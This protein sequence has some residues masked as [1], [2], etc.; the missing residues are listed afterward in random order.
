MEHCLK[1]LKG[2]KNK[3]VYIRP[4]QSIKLTLRPTMKYFDMCSKHKWM[5]IQK[6]NPHRARPI[7]II[8]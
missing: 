8:P 1:K 7:I 3:I 5:I 6:P 4:N 2:L